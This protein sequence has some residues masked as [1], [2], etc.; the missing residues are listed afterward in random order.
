MNS[1]SQGVA[2]RV[3]PYGTCN[4]FAEPIKWVAA[5]SH[6]KWAGEG[7]LRFCYRVRCVACGH[8]LKANQRAWQQRHEWKHREERRGQ[9][10]NT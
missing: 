2:F 4:L 10:C 9:S 1:T 6:S 5:P 3:G 7:A 8:L